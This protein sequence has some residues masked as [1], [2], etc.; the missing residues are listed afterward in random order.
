MD[1]IGCKVIVTASAL[2]S[3]SNR[4][5]EVVVFKKTNLILLVATFAILIMGCEKKEV[6]VEPPKAI[7]TV[8]IWDEGVLRSEP[9]LNSD[10]VSNMALGEKVIWLGGSSTDTLKNITFLNIKLSDGTTGWASNSLLATDAFPA[11]SVIK[12][13]IY[14][15][16]DL[17]TETKDVFEP[18]EILAVTKVAGD[19]IEVVG[20]KNQNAGWIHAKNVSKTDADVAVALLA[21]KALAE[22]KLATKTEKIEFILGNAAFSKSVFIKD[23]EQMHKELTTPEPEVVEETSGS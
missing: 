15:R 20:E 14:R 10:V 19:W 16:P 8:C 12:E 21:K 11:V 23:L 13:S 3:N 18:M 6:P 7:P 17:V 4:I 9:T 1:Y 5:M 22:N 2:F